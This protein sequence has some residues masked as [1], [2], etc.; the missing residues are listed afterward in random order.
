MWKGRYPGI[1]QND[2]KT[3]LVAVPPPKVLAE[4]G[5]NVAPMLEGIL[6]RAV[7]KRTLAQFRDTHLP[8]LI[9]GDLRV[10]DAERFMTRMEA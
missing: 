10:K 7:E 3:I 2:V 9:A 5:R 8:K 1:N 4:F 6:D